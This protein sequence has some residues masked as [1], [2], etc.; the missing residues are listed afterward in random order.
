MSLARPGTYLRTTGKYGAALVI[1]DSA[2]A[3]RA[4]SRNCSSVSAELAGAGPMTRYLPGS[5][6]AAD[7]WKT[8]V[9]PGGG[10]PAAGPGP[11]VHLAALRCHPAA[12]RWWRW[13]A[14]RP[15]LLV[16]LF[17]SIERPT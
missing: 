3:W 5:R 8:L 17:G 9:R 16:E 14:R 2:T 1:P 11:P 4:C 7:K 15:G 12:D 6:P 10:P 13:C